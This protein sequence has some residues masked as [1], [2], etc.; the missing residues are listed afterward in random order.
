M[1]EQARS[2][3]FPKRLFDLFVLFDPLL[4]SGAEIDSN[5]PRPQ[6]IRKPDARERPDDGEERAVEEELREDAGHR[7]LVHV[8]IVRPERGELDDAE[9]A[10]EEREG[11]EERPFD[12][13]TPPHEVREPGHED[14]EDHGLRDAAVHEARAAQ[15]LLNRALVQGPCDERSPIRADS[16]CSRWR[17]SSRGS[18]R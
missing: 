14:G 18:S 16:R 5:R 17:A 2:C 10:P 15:G 8:G 1:F 7:H 3:A 9:D 13:A 6:R 12:D 11:E 4:A